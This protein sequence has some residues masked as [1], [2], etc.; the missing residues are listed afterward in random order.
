MILNNMKDLKLAAFKNLTKT[1]DEIAICPTE[2]YQLLIIN[3]TYGAG[4]TRTA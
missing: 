3:G 4:K 2:K 1:H